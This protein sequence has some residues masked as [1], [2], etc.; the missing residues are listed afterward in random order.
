M[1]ATGVARPRAQGQEIT[2]TA[3]P[4]DRQNRTLSPPTKYHS[5]AATSAMPMTTGTNTALMRSASREMGALEE[6]ASSISRTIC[7]RVVSLPTR[8]ASS[9]R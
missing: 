6:A 2:S 3:M 7:E 8:R 4:M 9:S 1:M 5:S